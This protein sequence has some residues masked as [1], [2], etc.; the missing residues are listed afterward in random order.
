MSEFASLLVVA[1]IW[2]FVSLYKAG[3]KK[4]G[5]K[6]AGG[7]VNR[8]ARPGSPAL[9][10]QV[11]PEKEAVRPAPSRSSNFPVLSKADWGSLGASPIEGTDPCHDSPN[12]YQSGSLRVD[13]PEGT[14]PCHDDPA[15]LRSG[16]LRTDRPEGTDPC[17]DNLRAV[18]YGGGE[19]EEEESSPLTLSWAGNEIVKGF[20]YGEILN[21]KRA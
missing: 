21:R 17:H 7:T 15:A 16:S 18:P 12:A 6:A 9:K 13:R 20:I 3:S 2:F 4:D 1:A 11:Q 14:D 5:K 10:A 19:E 8:S